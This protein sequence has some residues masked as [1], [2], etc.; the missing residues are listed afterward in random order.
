MSEPKFGRQRLYKDILTL[1]LHKR[2]IS[3]YCVL[4]L[5]SYVVGV[6][7]CDKSSCMYNS[8]R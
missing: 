3:A 7:I 2:F 8:H 6:V 5:L 1:T 4:C